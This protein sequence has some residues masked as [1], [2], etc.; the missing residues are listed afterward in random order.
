MR[1]CIKMSTEIKFEGLSEFQQKLQEIEKKYPFETEVELKKL[2]KNLKK[3]AQDKTPKKTGK[4][5]KAYELSNVEYSTGG[6]SFIT[7]TNTSPIFHLVERGHKQ[8]DKKGNVVGKG[9][10]PGVH[11]VENSV[12]ELDNEMEA[13]IN[14]WM[15]GLLGGMK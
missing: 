15:D 2:G 10:V 4:L 13:E 7:M 1:K 8:T 3:N 14:K 6:S 11:M 9:F 5:R 12:T